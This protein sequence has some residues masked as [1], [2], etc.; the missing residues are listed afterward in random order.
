MVVQE[1]NIKKGELKVK[2][3]LFFFE[4]PVLQKNSEKSF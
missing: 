4:R 1:K 3:N 2:K